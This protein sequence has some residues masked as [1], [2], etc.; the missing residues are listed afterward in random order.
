MTC[1]CVRRPR[2]RLVRGPA[3]VP[4]GATA[5]LMALTI[6]VI[7]R[8]LIRLILDR[9]VDL[10]AVFGAL[11]VYLL[12]GLMFGFLIGLIATAVDS[13]YFAQGTDGSQSDRVYF[14]FTTLTTTGFGDLTPRTRP[15]HALAVLEM[16]MGQLYLVTV[17][18]ILVGNFVGQR[19][20]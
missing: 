15:G 5:V 10:T 7:S 2:R 8:G 14:S 12:I 20:Q 1:E 4:L 3:E 19:R 16:L 11:T 18:G 17:I 9:G 13:A 6:V